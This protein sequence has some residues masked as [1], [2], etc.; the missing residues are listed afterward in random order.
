LEQ[1]LQLARRV[2]DAQAHAEA[3]RV[4]ARARERVHRLE[5]SAVNVADV[6]VHVIKTVVPPGTHLT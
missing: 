2:H 3:A 1:L 6:A 5:V 4:E